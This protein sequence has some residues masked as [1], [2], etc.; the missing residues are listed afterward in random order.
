MMALDFPL[1]FKRQFSKS[2]DVDSTFATK[3]ELDAYLNNPL[4]YIGQIAT[5][6]EVEGP[7]IYNKTNLEYAEEYIKN[8]EELE[9][10]KKKEKEEK[11]KAEKEALAQAEKD[12]ESSTDK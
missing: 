3:A 6:D 11:R 9:A 12:I 4:R 10:K 7:S 1:Q 2:L 8:Y 5:C